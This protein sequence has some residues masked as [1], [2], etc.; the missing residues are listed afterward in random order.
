[1]ICW[2]FDGF[3]GFFSGFAE[4]LDINLFL[5]ISIIE[6]IRTSL[7]VLAKNMITKVKTCFAFFSKL[8]FC[9]LSVSAAKISPPF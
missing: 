8:F 5:K 6:V 3:S 9:V 4:T 2:F 7:Q 1:M